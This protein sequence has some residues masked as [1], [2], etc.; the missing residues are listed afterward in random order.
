MKLR[1]PVNHLFRLF[2]A[3]AKIQLSSVAGGHYHCICHCRFGSQIQQR[4]GDLL[5]RK[6]QLLT[7]G[8]R[9]SFVIDAKCKNSDSP[10]KINEALAEFRQNTG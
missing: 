6:S 7:Q 1:Q 2:A 8:D 4:I 9:R 3:A 10:E 5:R